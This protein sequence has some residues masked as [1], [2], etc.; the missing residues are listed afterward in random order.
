MGNDRAAAA[1]YLE[2]RP[3][4]ELRSYVACTWVSALEEVPE[5]HRGVLPDGCVD[6]ICAVGREPFVAGPDTEPQRV[7]TP[8]EML[9]GVRFVPGVA[10]ALLGV[11]ISEIRNQTVPLSC[12]RRPGEVRALS[13][14]VGEASSPREMTERLE[15]YIALRIRSSAEPD[16]LVGSAIDAILRATLNSSRTLGRRFDISERHLRRRFVGNVGYGPK[17]FERIARFRHFIRTGQIY[18]DLGLAGLAAEA[19]YADQSHLTRECVRLGGRTPR[20]LL[21][22]TPT[23]D[24][25]KTVEQPAVTLTR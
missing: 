20:L 19:G 16:P 12:I 22:T 18:R 9:I 21:D 8:S 4:T 1:S 5:G 10:A 24:L 7:G 11:P 25:F 17:T 13:G 2:L 15:E 23:S 14:R 3:R 6:I